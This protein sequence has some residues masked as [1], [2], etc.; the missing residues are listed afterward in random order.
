MSKEKR[1][2]PRGSAGSARGVRVHRRRGLR[3][4]VA[5]PPGTLGVRKLKRPRPVA[6][7]EVRP[8]MERPDPVERPVLVL[9]FGSQFV[10]L[11]ARRVRERHAFARFVRHDMTA[12]RVR[13]MDPLALI[14]SGGPASVY[15]AGAP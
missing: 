9:D 13:E 2:K 4:S 11:I 1:P 7:R 15:E 10:Q 14:L 3:F 6:P 8:F 5:V 12:E